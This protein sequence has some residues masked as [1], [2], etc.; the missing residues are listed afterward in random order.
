MN[1]NQ[2]AILAEAKKIVEEV[3]QNQ[4]KS[5]FVFHNLDHTQ[6]VVTA[7][8]EIEAC[9]QLNDN[10]RFVLYLSAWFHDTGFITGQAEEHEKESIKLAADFLH[11]RNA[12]QEIIQ[13]VSSCIGAT[14]LPQAALNLV[15]KIICDADFFHLGTN[16]FYKR[17]NLLRQEIQSF[18]KS[19]FSDEEWYM[20]NIGF[21]KSHQYFTGYCQ[22][23]LEPVKQ[24]W[25]KELQKKIDMGMETASIKD[26]RKSA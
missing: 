17:N 7:A 15:E 3:L 24:K 12:D 13:R 21:L 9:Y 25:I 8:Q 4:V 5:L 6:Q 18:N 11:C 16:N 1:E 14:R 10:D 19:N 23:K 2:L 26:N 22:L 20:L